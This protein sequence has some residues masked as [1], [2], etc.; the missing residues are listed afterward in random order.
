MMPSGLALLRQPMT[1]RGVPERLA[2][3]ARGSQAL[4]LTRECRAC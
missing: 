2:C 4:E 3:S 1:A